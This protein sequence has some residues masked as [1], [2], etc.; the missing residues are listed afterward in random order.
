MLQ[1]TW[2]L[3]FQGPNTALLSLSE[4]ASQKQGCRKSSRL[5]DVPMRWFEE[6]RY[7]LIL[8]SASTPSGRLKGHAMPD[9]SRGYK[10]A[11]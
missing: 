4:T 8:A 2:R 7:T 11:I 1:L 3:G 5:V 9:T 6:T 10:S